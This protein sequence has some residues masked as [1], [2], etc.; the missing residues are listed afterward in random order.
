M[1]GGT[2]AEYE[3][4]VTSLNLDKL[5]ANI[6][7]QSESLKYNNKEVINSISVIK[8]SGEEKISIVT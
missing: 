5:K 4:K 1:T 2:Q 8:V 6:T 3:Y 7:K